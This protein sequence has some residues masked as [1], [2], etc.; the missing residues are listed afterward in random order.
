ME[1]I[2]PH[3]FQYTKPEPLKDTPVVRK[4]SR[5]KFNTKQDYIPS[6]TG[7]K[8]AAAV[9]QLEDQ[10]ALHPDAHMFFIKIK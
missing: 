6:M 4:S 3:P 8:Y 7:Y 2:V 10:G 5:V 9:D 1:S